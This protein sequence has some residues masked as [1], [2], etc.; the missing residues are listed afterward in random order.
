MSRLREIDA[1][2]LFERFLATLSGSALRTPDAGETEAQFTGS[3]LAPV[4]SRMVQ[5]LSQSGVEGLRSTGDGAAGVTPVSFLGKLFYPDIALHH[6]Q[7]DLIA[8]EVKFLR[9]G[10]RQS[11]I[12]SAL[13]QAS[14]YSLAGYRFALV[15]LLDIDD[16]ISDDQLVEAI[17][18]V[19]ARGNLKLCVRR[20]RGGAVFDVGG[21][22]N[23]HSRIS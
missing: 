7:E 22:A 21:E 3:T 20:A 5:T 2:A 16:S 9:S 18:L 12:A 14:L 17:S 10:Q 8:C 23:S 6:F 15:F 11:S 1:Q 13:G 19:D 4:I